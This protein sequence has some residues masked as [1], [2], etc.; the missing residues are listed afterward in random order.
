MSDWFLDDEFDKFMSYPYKPDT[1]ILSTYWSRIYMI[2]MNHRDKRAYRRN[3]N[4]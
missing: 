4:V 3:R 1:I 2:R